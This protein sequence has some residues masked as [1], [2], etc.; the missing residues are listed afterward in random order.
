VPTETYHISSTGEKPSFLLY[1]F[2][3]H[4]PTQATT[5]PAKPLN[6]TD[7]TDYCEELVL[8]LSSERLGNS[9]AAAH[10]AVGLQC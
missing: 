9:K 10:D 1:G 7:I 4:Y 5:S 3:C 8:C 2:D 6:L